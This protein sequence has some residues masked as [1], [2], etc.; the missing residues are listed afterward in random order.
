MILE[1]GLV[2]HL[3]SDTT[4]LSLVAQG[5]RKRI[6]PMVIPQKAKAVDQV[7]CVVYQITQEERQKVYCGTEKLISVTLQLDSYAVDLITAR[8][9]SAAIRAVLVDFRGLMGDVLV[10]DV[11]LV[12]GLT[13]YDMEP[14]LMRVMDTY[15][16]WYEEE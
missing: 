5:D 3:I 4:V 9:L 6:F 2:E 1:L 14:G 15:T 7:P 16:I 12:G 11:T 13:L 10:R 8:R